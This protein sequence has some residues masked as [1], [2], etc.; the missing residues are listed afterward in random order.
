MTILIS[1]GWRTPQQNSETPGAAKGSYHLSGLAV[2]VHIPPSADKL[3]K[4]A[5]E[6]GF[7]VLAK[8]YPHHVHIDLREGWTPKIEPCDECACKRIRGEGN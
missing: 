5:A 1:S 4:A 6:C 2:D 7:F 3:R 8:E